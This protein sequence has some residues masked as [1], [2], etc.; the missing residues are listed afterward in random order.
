MIDPYYRLPA[1]VRSLTYIRRNTTSTCLPS[2]ADAVGDTRAIHHADR[3]STQ[4]PYDQDGAPL[5]GPFAGSTCAALTAGYG[6][7]GVKG[8]AFDSQALYETYGYKDLGLTLEEYAVLKAKAK[9][10]GTYFG[11]SDAVTW[12]TASAVTSSAGYNPVIYIEKPGSLRP[13]RV[14]STPTAGP[15]TL[16]APASIRTSSWSSMGAT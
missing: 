16:A 4:F 8:S 15:P 5:G 13:L 14:I 11:P 2:A 7:Y 10:A 1:G 9:A 12:P 6:D 3:C